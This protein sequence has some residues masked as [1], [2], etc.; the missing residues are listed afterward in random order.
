VNAPVDWEIVVAVAN[1]I[2]SRRFCCPLFGQSARFRGWDAERQYVYRERIALMCPPQEPISAVA[3]VVAC[4]DVG[5]KPYVPAE[6]PA[7]PMDGWKQ[8]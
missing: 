8:A 3:H 7:S 6:Y 2:R 4:M 5:E 1:G